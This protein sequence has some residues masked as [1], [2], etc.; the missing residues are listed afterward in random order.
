[1]GRGRSTPAGQA[2]AARTRVLSHALSRARVAYWEALLLR[3]RLAVVILD[4]IALDV[5]TESKR[6]DTSGW[7]LA[8]AWP[9]GWPRLTGRARPRT[10]SW[11]R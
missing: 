11:T 9:S 3:P 8:L 4:A 6:I 7:R 1:M 2:I 5:G 10:R